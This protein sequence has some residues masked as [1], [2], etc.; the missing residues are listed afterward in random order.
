MAIFQTN[1][2]T[3][4][5]SLAQS[6]LFS[7]QNRQGE[8]NGSVSLAGRA[9]EGSRGEGKKSEKNPWDVFPPQEGLGERF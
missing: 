5:V 3:P 8:K 9:K 2:F 6:P 7:G 4:P 1:D